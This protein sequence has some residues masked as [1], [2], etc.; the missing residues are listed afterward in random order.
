MELFI[1]ISNL[2]RVAIENYL[3][4]ALLLQAHHSYS[5]VAGLLHSGNKTHHLLLE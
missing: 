4:Y 1:I 2:S 3:P 5:T